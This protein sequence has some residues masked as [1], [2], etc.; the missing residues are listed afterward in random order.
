[1]EL[2]FT[3]APGKRI[4]RSFRPFDFSGD[5]HCRCRLIKGPIRDF[6]LMVDRSRMKAETTVLRSGDPPLDAEPEEPR[7]S[8]TPALHRQSLLQAGPGREHYLARL[9]PS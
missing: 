9:S 8:E 5:W 3:Q 6:N 1:M 7:E 2:D 4:D